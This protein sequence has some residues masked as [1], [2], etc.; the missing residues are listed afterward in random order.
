MAL[1]QTQ[2]SS[3]YVAIFNRASEGEGNTY[4]QNTGLSMAETA[5]A[6]LAT[7]DAQEYFGDSLESNQAF[8]EHIYANTLNK[9]IQDDPEGIAYWVEALDNGA[10]RG[11]VVSDLIEAIYTY[12]DSTDPVTKAAYD[13]FVN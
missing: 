11:Q 8:I 7:P 2:V 3:L 1:T 6:M 10:D 12:A 4:W 5:D 13:Q 9:T